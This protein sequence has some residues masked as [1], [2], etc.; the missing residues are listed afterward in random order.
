VCELHRR[1]A[2]RVVLFHVRR[3]DDGDAVVPGELATLNLLLGQVRDLR[4]VPRRALRRRSAAWLRAH[5][6]LGLV[7][8]APFLA[9]L[10]L[11][12]E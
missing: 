12:L 8:A 10:H 9:R 6:S 5:S 2:A 3:L 4:T 7:A 11:V 1:A